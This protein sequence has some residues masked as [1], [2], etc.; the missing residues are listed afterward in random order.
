MVRL[1]VLTELRVKDYEMFPGDPPGSGLRWSFREGVT[2]VAGIN[3][4]GKTTLLTMILRALTGRYDLTGEGPGESL[5]VTL[6]KNPV[7]LNRPHIE[8]FQDRVSDGATSATVDL[9]ARIGDSV[10]SITRRL[11]NLV[12][13]ALAVDGTPVPLPRGQDAREAPFQ[14]TLADL[15]G[16]SS[17]V[18]V[19][20]VLHY[21]I[22]FYENRPGALWDTDA[23]R[24]LLRAMS[25]APEDATRFAEL[26]RQLQQADSRTRN[27][28]ARRARRSRLSP[29]SIRPTTDYAEPCVAKP[30]PS[31]SWP[32]SRPSR[33]C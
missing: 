13:Q 12:L 16:L 17:F 30:A 20:L 2:V 32:N 29:A 9:S 21:V 10:L 14:S 25:L 28:D 3:G 22:L 18:D 7:R 33:N 15:T 23:Q 8:L 31:G 6:P 24:H 19:L 26:E 5:G 27:V 11:D 1:P 4:L